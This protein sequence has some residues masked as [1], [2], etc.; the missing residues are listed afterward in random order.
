MRPK[1][2]PDVEFC[3]RCLEI[4]D[5]VHKTRRPIIITRDL[6]MLIPAGKAP[7]AAKQLRA[8]KR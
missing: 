2:M 4:I 8:K 6:V 3:R 1:R 5:E 7:C